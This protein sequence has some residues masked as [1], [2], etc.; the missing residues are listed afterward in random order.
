MGK[1]NTKASIVHAEWTSGYTA[2]GTAQEAL[3]ANG[4]VTFDQLV[5]AGVAPAAVPAA[6]AQAADDA[7][8]YVTAADGVWYVTP[9]TAAQAAS[10]AVIAVASK[11]VTVEALA[12]VAKAAVWKISTTVHHAHAS[13]LT[14]KEKA[15]K[16]LA[17]VL[18][19]E[20]AVHQAQ[21]AVLY[22]A[23]GVKHPPV[24]TTTVLAWHAAVHAA[25]LADTA[26]VAKAQEA[27]NESKQQAVA[28]VAA[29]AEKYAS[30]AAPEIFGD[31][32]HAS[33]LRPWRSG[34]AQKL[35]SNI[36]IISTYPAAQRTRPHAFPAGL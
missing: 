14:T 29:V 32:P 4:F 13:E 15:A 21:P 23:A 31:E 27:F 16:E 22:K 6:V 34:Q 20:F 8:V 36:S 26:W 1:K 18:A 10:D 24:P 35:G 9:I 12:E 7:K 28:E 5:A 11:T 33:G 30:A 19:K 2:A 17:H 25:V 3:L